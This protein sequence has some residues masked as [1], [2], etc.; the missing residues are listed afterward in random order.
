MS[1]HE[2]I[3]AAHISGYLAIAFSADCRQPPPSRRLLLPAMDL[4]IKSRELKTMECFVSGNI[5]ASAMILALLIILVSSA[6]ASERNPARE[7]SSSGSTQADDPATDESPE[8]PDDGRGWSGGPAG[9][10][11]VPPPLDRSALPRRE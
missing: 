4:V 3:K 8:S 7:D 5:K 10:P 1:A 2:I 11:T 6:T 9:T